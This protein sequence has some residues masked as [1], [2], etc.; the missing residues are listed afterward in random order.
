MARKLAKFAKQFRADDN[1]ELEV[2]MYSNTSASDSEIKGIP[3]DT[4]LAMRQ[5]LQTAAK[6]GVFEAK[7]SRI[8]VD[9]FYPGS[10]RHRC[11]LGGSASGGPNLPE[12]CRKT[13]IAHLD[14]VCAQRNFAFRFHLKREEP[15]NDFVP[16]N[17]GRPNYVRIQQEWCFVYQNA[18]AYVIKKVQSGGTSKEECLQKPLHFELEIELLRDPLFFEEHDDLLLADSLIEKALDL[19]G[20][21]DEKSQREELTMLFDTSKNDT[22]RQRQE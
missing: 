10:I 1:L 14:A 13:P 4:I 6:D 2:C 19:C 9:Y 8:Y 21:F 3:H 15:I 7:H 12:T 20:R 22:K 18:I 11:V 17:A 16:T 5:T